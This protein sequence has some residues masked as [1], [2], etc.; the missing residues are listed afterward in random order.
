MYLLREGGMSGQAGFGVGGRAWLSQQP[1][2]PLSPSQVRHLQLL[3][4]LQAQKRK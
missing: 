4:R 3:A 1:I 2:G